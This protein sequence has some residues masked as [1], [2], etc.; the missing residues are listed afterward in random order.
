MAHPNDNTAAAVVAGT[1]ILVPILFISA[2]YFT[3]KLIFG[4]YKK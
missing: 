1:V 2:I 3:S 4:G